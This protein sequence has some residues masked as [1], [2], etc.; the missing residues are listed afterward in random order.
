[1]TLGKRETN[2]DDGDGVETETATATAQLTATETK[3]QSEQASERVPERNIQA[4]IT[5]FTEKAVN[6]QP[7]RAGQTDEEI[8]NL[9]R[10]EA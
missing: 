1:M 3:P 2:D 10:A 5:E 9:C 7:G 8:R 6:G 4:I